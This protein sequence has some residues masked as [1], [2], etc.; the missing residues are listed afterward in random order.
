MNVSMNY[1]EMMQGLEKENIKTWFDLG[2]FIDRL[3]DNKSLP[4]VCINGDHNELK[5]ELQKGGVGF[6]SFYYSVDGV[7]IEVDKYAKIMKKHLP[8]ADIHYIAGEFYPEADELIDPSCKKFAIPEAKSFD[9][10]PLYNDF[11]TTKIERGGEKYNRLILDYWA[12]TLSIVQQLGKY[13]EDNN[14]NLLYLINVCSNPGN[15]ALSLACVLVSELMGIPVINNCHDYYWEGGNRKVDIKNK[16]LKEGPRDFF[17]T[18]SHIGEFFSIIEM[19]FPWQSRSWLTVNINKQQSVHVV[20]KNGHN[21]A[22]VVELGTGVDL[23][24]YLNVTKRTRINALSQIQEILSR[25]QEPLI[26]YGAGDVIKNCLVNEENPEP[27]L[28][29]LGGQT[30]PLQ[31]FTDEN[32]IFLQ[33]TRIVSRKRIGA[34]FQLIKRLFANKDLVQRF[35]ESPLLKLTILISGPIPMGQFDYFKKLL[36]RFHES[37]NEI[38]ELFHERIF[39][40]FTFSEMDK[41]QFKI[42]YKNPLSIPEMYSIASLVLLPSKTEG[43]GLPIIESAASGVPIFCR[44]YY[45]ENVYSAVIGE[46]LPE[47]ERLKV[48]EYDGKEITQE[49]VLVIINKVFFPHKFMDETNQNIQ[50]VRNRYSLESLSIEFDGLLKRLCIQLQAKEE[51][52]EIAVSSLKE[53]KEIVNF[54]NSDL[55]S[56]L[57]TENRQYTPGYS[58]LAFMTQLKSLIDPSFFRVEEQEIR[59]KLFEFAKQLILDNPRKLEQKQIQGFYN[60][61]ENIFSHSNGEVEIQHDHSFA[62]RHRSKKHFPYQDFTFQELTGLINLMYIKMINPKHK[63][64]IIQTSHF[65]TDWKL[66]LSQLTSSRF[67][68]ID[69]REKLFEKLKSNVPIAYFPGKFIKYELE[70]FALQSVRA[71]F[72]LLLKD[73][74]TA[75]HLEDCSFGIAPIYIFAQKFRL[76][77]WLTKEDIENY[78]ETGADKELKLLYKYKILRI[79]ESNQ[80]GIGMHLPQIGERGI[81]ILRQIRDQKGFLI[82]IRRNSAIMSDIIDID[83]FH[84]GKASYEW[85]SNFLGIPLNSGFIQYVPAGIRTTLAYPTP[86]QT[87]KDFSDLLNSN[88]YAEVCKKFGEEKVLLELKKDAEKNGNP[89]QVVLEKLNS[90][91]GKTDDIDSTYVSG[92]YADGLPWNGA[93]ATVKTGQSNW[94]FVAV[95]SSDKTKKVTTFLSEFNQ[96]SKGLGRIAWNGGYILN[97]ELV[98]KLGLPES[99][100]GSPLGLIISNGKVVSPPLFNKPAFF[101]NKDGTLDI[102]PVN[103]RKGISIS[104]DSH[105]VDFTSAMYNADSSKPGNAFYD[106]L[107]HE[108]EIEV[109]GRTIVRLAGNVIK[110]IIKPGKDKMVQLIPVGLTLVIDDSKITKNWKVGTTLKIVVNGLEDIL[111]GIGAGPLLIN[112]G[113]ECIDMEKGGWKSKNSI[114]T[115]AARLD[116]TDMRGPK[117]AVGI[118]A[119]DNLVVLTVNGRIRES[120][121][122]THHDMAEI[123]LKY[124]IVKGMGFDPGGSSTLVVD[125]KTLNISPYNQNYENNIYALPPEP[126]AVANAVIGFVPRKP[127]VKKNKNN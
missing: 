17:F 92:K 15:V 55:K 40:A 64:E 71:R 124:G 43:R 76:G 58:K 120:V 106:L 37:K 14:I 34:G 61:V 80:L 73:E 49:H 68:G 66:A 5:Q 88:L 33:P 54:T 47:H 116:Y 3:R 127:E 125:G 121:G 25:Y 59:G 101:V 56:L 7:T 100:I 99:F 97:A 42:K 118:D 39:L 105:T 91:A 77:K 112:D 90:P 94:E 19:L 60:T 78:L 51:H 117:I 2:L 113:K 110:E 114:K 87:A 50:V 6:V 1:N 31:H 62:Y 46:H 85:V 32:I 18:N 41:D 69:D 16:K 22:N 74:L 104:S 122:A 63:R 52:M 45:P 109:N 123:L 67:L 9:S 89:A 10:W 119:E 115:Q 4:N 96:K 86:V 29:K 8:T 65:F 24:T 102:Q 38:P 79:V 82:S 13:V 103:C 53:F 27:I 23:D 48:I 95:A 108:D 35:T 28:L 20:K 93:M 83:R 81:K 126:R 36:N 44:R 111:H 21:P 107:H 57:N 84:I 30:A 75:Q 98:G 11:F 26:A 70:F 12:N 72:S